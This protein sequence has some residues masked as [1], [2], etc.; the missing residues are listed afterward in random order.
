MDREDYNASIHSSDGG[1]ETDASSV[2][3]DEPLLD[4]IK[5]AK[6]RG[7]AHGHVDKLD[8]NYCGLCGTIHVETCHMVQS[9]DNLV[10]YRAMLMEVTNEEAIEIRVSGFIPARPVHLCAHE[11]CSAKQSRPLTRNS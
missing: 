5:R 8:E 7:L 2:V 3:L 11:L 1:S 9:P 10:E 6:K 4:V